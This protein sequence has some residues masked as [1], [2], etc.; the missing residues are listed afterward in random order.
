MGPELLPLKH[1][2]GKHVRAKEKGL[3]G[4]PPPCHVPHPERGGVMRVPQT[5]QADLEGCPLWVP[6]TLHGCLV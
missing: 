4:T 5:Q 6:L 1:L 3:G 2:T